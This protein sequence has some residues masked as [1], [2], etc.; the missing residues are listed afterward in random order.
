MY[1]YVGM[2]LYVIYINC[3][4]SKIKHFDWLPLVQFGGLAYSTKLVAIAT[5]PPSPG[6]CH[7]VTACFCTHPSWIHQ[8]LGVCLF[9]SPCVTVISI[10]KLNNL[11]KNYDELWGAKKRKKNFPGTWKLML[12]KGLKKRSAVKKRCERDS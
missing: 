11:V 2:Y 7:R 6:V 1:I 3:D 12:L 4:G 9:T 5:E 10:V 8:K